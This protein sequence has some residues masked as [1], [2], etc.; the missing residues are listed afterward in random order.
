LAGDQ[1]DGKVGGGQGH[2]QPALAVVLPQQHHGG[3][4]SAGHLGKKLGLADEGLA[5]AQDGFL[6][7]GR[8]D[9]R[10][11]FMAQTAVGAVAQGGQGGA[12]GG[13]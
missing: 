1:F 11:H 4:F 2:A 9:E 7:D 12:R 6:A 13:G 8:G 5:G 3:L 10:V